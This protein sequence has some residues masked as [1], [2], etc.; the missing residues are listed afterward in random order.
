MGRHSPTSVCSDLTGQ[1]MRGNARGCTGLRDILIRLDRYSDLEQTMLPEPDDY[2]VIGMPI[3]WADHNDRLFWHCRR[4]A[5]TS[6]MSSYW[7]CSRATPRLRW[8]T[9]AAT[10][11]ER[12]RTEQLTLIARIGRTLTADLPLEQLV[13]SAARCYP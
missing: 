11:E 9:R 12:R 8:R 5:S 6:R 4:A 3:W 13:Q 1:M 7:S 10:A 2:A